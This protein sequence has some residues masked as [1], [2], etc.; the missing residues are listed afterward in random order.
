MEA[1]ILPGGA[2]RRAWLVLVA[3][4]MAMWPGCLRVRFDRCAE[5][6]PHADCVDGS[7]PADGGRGLDA[8]APA[9]GGQSPD[10][11]APADGGPGLDA[12]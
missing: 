2:V 7:A 3:A 10:A 6:P 5:D 9:D 4:G 8:S 1:M 12:G 11:S